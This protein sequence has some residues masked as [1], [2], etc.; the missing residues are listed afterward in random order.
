M[1]PSSPHLPLLLV[2]KIE[3]CCEELSYLISLQ[4]TTICT[5]MAHYGYIDSL[6]SYVERNPLIIV[7]IALGTWLFGY[8]NR[9]CRLVRLSRDGKLYQTNQC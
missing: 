8:W 6:I 1:P 2:P 7:F 3:D 9:V 4:E 5:V